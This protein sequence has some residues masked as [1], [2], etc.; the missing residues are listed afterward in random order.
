MKDFDVNKIDQIRHKGE[1][2]L[3]LRAL[4]NN[5][6]MTRAR[7]SQELQVLLQQQAIPELGNRPW[8]QFWKS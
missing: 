6:M 3:W 7:K 5:E 4:R 8:W 1:L 2:R